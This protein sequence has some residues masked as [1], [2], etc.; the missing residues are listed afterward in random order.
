[1]ESLRQIPPEQRTFVQKKFAEIDQKL[2]AY[3]LI[4]FAYDTPEMPRPAGAGDEARKAVF[5]QVRRLMQGAR[6][7]DDNHPP[8]AIPPL[9]A[10]TGSTAGTA[11][12]SD[13]S[14]AS[15]GA[16]AAWLTPR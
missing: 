7:I 9:G 3:D 2:M 4:R 1:M 5:D 12:A 8:A 11:S 6:M 14:D 15:G 16:D 13:T 10:S